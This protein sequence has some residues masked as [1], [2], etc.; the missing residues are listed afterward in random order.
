MNVEE[1]LR[2]LVLLEKVSPD[3]SRIRARILWCVV[4]TTL[5]LYLQLP[6]GGLLQV[7]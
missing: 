2:L 3:W 6:Y 5:H 1:K 7:P 4:M